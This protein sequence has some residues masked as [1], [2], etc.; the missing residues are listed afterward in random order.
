MKL[1]LLIYGHYMQKRQ[2]KCWVYYRIWGCYYFDYCFN[3]ISQHMLHFHL[4]HALLYVCFAGYPPVPIGI[5]LKKI[6]TS[7]SV[8]WRFNSTWNK[9]TVFIVEKRQSSTLFRPSNGDFAFWKFAGEVCYIM[10]FFP[11]KA[12]FRLYMS[13]LFFICNI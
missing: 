3:S 8:S 1:N 2:S 9:S 5:K 7:L 12:F 6:K 13:D 11:S 4:L 10:Q